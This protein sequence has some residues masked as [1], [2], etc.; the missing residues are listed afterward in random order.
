MATPL[1]IPVNGATLLQAPPWL[2]KRIA[3]SLA[4]QQTIVVSLRAI[5]LADPSRGEIP[6]ELRKAVPALRASLPS[7]FEKLTRILGGLARGRKILTCAALAQ[8]QKPN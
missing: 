5:A 8:R 1:K 6:E 4:Q 7:R 3:S 2:E